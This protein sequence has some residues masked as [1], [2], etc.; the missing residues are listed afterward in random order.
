MSPSLAGAVGALPVTCAVGDKRVSGAAIRLP[1]TGGDGLQLCDVGF[2]LQQSSYSLLYLPYN[3]LS[4]L[5][6]DKEFFIA[7]HLSDCFNFLPVRPANAA[8][9]SP[10]GFTEGGGG[11]VTDGAVTAG[12]VTDGAVTDGAVTVV[13]TGSGGGGGGG[14]GGTVP[15]TDGAVTD[16]AVTD[17]AVTDGAVIVVDTGSGCG[18]GGTVPVTD[19]AVTDGAVTDGAVTDGA[20]TA[21]AVTDGIN[22]IVVDTR[23]G[24]CGSGGINLIVVD[25]PDGVNVIVV[26]IR[27]GGGGG[28]GVTVI[29]VDIRGGLTE[30]FVAVAADVSIVIPVEGINGETEDADVTP[31]RDGFGGRTGLVGLGVDIIGVVANPGVGAIPFSKFFKLT[32]NSDVNLGESI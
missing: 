16:G 25:T 19:G 12:P 1:V 32:I 20:V 22:V 18:G 17:G 14:G 29:V 21:G 6:F 31:N 4:G 8:V 2:S 24:C 9:K 23:G 11:A 30:G 26:D 7:A 10:C 15:V 3:A 5:Y 27:E 13:D 28:G